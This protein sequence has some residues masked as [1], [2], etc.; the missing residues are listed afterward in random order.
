MELSNTVAKFIIFAIIGFGIGFAGFEMTGNNDVAS[1]ET[2]TETA[3]NTEESTIT[4]D[5]STSEET[6]TETVS[7]N[8]EILNTKG[9]LACHS[10]SSLDLEGGAT[11]PDLSQAFTNV[12]GK[13]GKPLDEFLQ[14][15]TSAV[16]SSVIGGNPLTDEEI[17]QVVDALQEA[18]EK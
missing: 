15:P 1:T 7:A 18:S 17:Q 11:G 12:E 8:G 3:V 2:P 9:C 4:A 14:E 16:M 13:H 5:D 6:A 10:V